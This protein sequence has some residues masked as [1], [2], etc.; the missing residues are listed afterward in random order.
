MSSAPSWVAAYLRT[1]PSTFVVA[2][3]REMR[4]EDD[5]SSSLVVAR[6]EDGDVV[7]AVRWICSSNLLGHHVEAVLEAGRLL[8]G[9]LLRLLDEVLG[10]LGLDVDVDVRARSGPS[11]PWS[12]RA[13]C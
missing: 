12:R 4:P 13:C 7:V 1:S 2:W 5:C 11:G 8:L 6:S 10:V 3:G 9:V